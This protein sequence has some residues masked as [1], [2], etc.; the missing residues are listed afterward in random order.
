[1]LKFKIFLF[2][3]LALVVG[4]GIW[5]NSKYE[6]VAVHPFFDDEDYEL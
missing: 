5:M 3:I 2:L 1:M 6:V 4:L